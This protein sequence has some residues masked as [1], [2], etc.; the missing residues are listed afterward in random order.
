MKNRVR[1]IRT[2]MKCCGTRT[3]IA[4][5]EEAIEEPMDCLLCIVQQP[6]Q[7]ENEAGVLLLGH[8]YT[9]WHI[10]NVFDQELYIWLDFSLEMQAC[11]LHPP[12][13]RNYTGRSLLIDAVCETKGEAWASGMGSWEGGQ[14][15]VGRG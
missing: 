10:Q 15:I 4:T 3:M 9:K 8:A 5:S 1:K 2:H 12:R 6:R 14:Y 11:Q 7:H 13:G